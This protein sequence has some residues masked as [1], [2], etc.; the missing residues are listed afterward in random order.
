MASSIPGPYAKS[1]V[2]LIPGRYGRG[3]NTTVD[4]FSR[5]IPALQNEPVNAEIIKGVGNYGHP[6]SDWTLSDMNEAVVRVLI[7]NVE[8]VLNMAAEEDWYYAVCPRVEGMTAMNVQ[9]TSVFF[10]PPHSQESAPRTVPRN[11]DIEQTVEQYGMTRMINGFQ[12]DTETTMAGVERGMEWFL[13]RV[14]MMQVGIMETDKYTII[15]GIMNM[16]RVQRVK[17]DEL[18]ELVQSRSRGGVHDMILWQNEMTFS[19]V[20]K[21]DPIRFWRETSSADFQFLG[22][23]P[24]AAV[25]IMHEHS[26]RA[27]IPN[28]FYKNRSRGDM[29]GVLDSRTA[30]A[31]ILGTG[32][33]FT[34]NFRGNKGQSLNP[35]GQVLPLGLYNPMVDP[36]DECA[37]TPYKTD[38]R[39]IKMTTTT[40]KGMMVLEPLEVF[41]RSGRWDL[42]TGELNSL[43]DPGAW[44]AA[45]EEQRKRITGSAASDAYH[46]TIAQTIFGRDADDAAYVGP[47]THWGSVKTSTISTKRFQSCAKSV[48]AEL[49][50]SSKI[51]GVVD[52]YL[53]LV[54]EAGAAS[55]T[56]AAG[57]DWDDTFKAAVALLGKNF[58]DGTKGCKPT[59]PGLKMSPMDASTRF[60][61]IPAL[62]TPLK[63][64]PPGFTSLAAMRWLR[65]NTDGA[66]KTRLV[67]VVDGADELAKLLKGKFAT[68]V[69][70]DPDYAP[71]DMAGAKE[72]DMLFTSAILPR[73]A[74]VIAMQAVGVGVVGSAGASGVAK[75]LYANAQKYYGGIANPLAFV[76]KFEP[77]GADSDDTLIKRAI[78]MTALRNFV[79]KPSGGLVQDPE[80]VLA[81]VNLADGKTPSAFADEVVDKLRKVKTPK[82]AYLRS[83]GELRNAFEDLIAGVTASA[84]GTR[85]PVMT[86]LLLEPGQVVK[87][88]EL[89]AKKGNFT[90]VTIGKDGRQDVPANTEELKSYADFIKRN[91]GQVTFAAPLHPRSPLTYA[92]IG[93]IAHVAGLREFMRENGWPV[94]R[95][96][97]QTKGAAALRPA[98]MLTAATASNRVKNLLSGLKSSGVGARPSS[99]SSSAYGADPSGAMQQYFS[100]INSDIDLMMT[101]GF[102]EHWDEANA[103]ASSLLELLIIRLYMTTPTNLNKS[104]RYWATNNVR[105]PLNAAV[106][107]TLRVRTNPVIRIVPGQKTCFLAVGFQK[108]GRGTEQNTGMFSINHS[109]YTG[110]IPVQPKNV[111][112]YHNVDPAGYVSG[113]DAQWANFAKNTPGMVSILLPGDRL[114][115]AISPFGAIGVD[116]E[117]GSSLEPFASTT[118]SIAV[119]E[120]YRQ[121]RVR[122]PW[123]PEQHPNNP[124]G[125]PVEDPLFE[126]FSRDTTLFAGPHCDYKKHVPSASPIP[127]KYAT[128]DLR[129]ILDGRKLKPDD[130]LTLGSNNEL[131]VVV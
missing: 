79:K 4:F 2:E 56:N 118:Q 53:T 35:V 20:T 71:T 120:Q 103:M 102:A 76:K 42:Q 34:R 92:S 86:K 33:N 122:A 115:I 60:M 18:I 82:E 111:Q 32:V 50:D 90:D 59:N 9:V 10:R 108:T 72:V 100:C 95:R 105:I 62:G 89:L 75:S 44:A 39:R 74:V 23:N 101:E 67:R 125:V 52:E 73:R 99:S 57:D 21:E 107:R 48:I 84:N 3:T 17:W 26:A 24:A 51:N 112:I 64:M 8:E 78:L 7:S 38:Y 27:L 98:V 117:K 70:M 104:I 129:D 12:I 106:L 47:A 113:L 123:A 80:L 85:T 37:D 66:L 22:V 126:H 114:P 11:M 1:D 69:L 130:P 19:L 41:V 15:A 88:Q 54:E 109:Y 58:S 124:W 14:A 110:F 131:P 16:H 29:Q 81:G 93:A 121:N 63:T 127:T 45:G 91:D 119:F 5:L 128:S 30:V 87:L 65:D 36:H 55:L 40:D 28:D 97:G 83:S 25:T 61:N 43:V 49:P 94:A 46:V 77:T 13:E 96:A 116:G 68:S 6:K 31:E